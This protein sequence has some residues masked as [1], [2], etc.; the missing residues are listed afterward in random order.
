M[1]CFPAP[2]SARSK[3]L[4]S[5]GRGVCFWQR[6]SKSGFIH[7]NVCRKTFL[8]QW[9][10]WF[11]GW[12]LPTLRPHQNFTQ[13]EIRTFEN[14]TLIK[15]AKLVLFA[16][17][18]RWAVQD[19]GSALLCWP[20]DNILTY[21]SERFPR[22][23]VNKTAGVGSQGVSYLELLTNFHK[24]WTLFLSL[25]EAASLTCGFI[26]LLPVRARQWSTL[27]TSELSEV[28]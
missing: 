20:R 23:K 12:S 25:R 7:A 6:R 1:N 24:I 13:I 21:R 11:C 28:P 15:T 10:L 3:S 14:N 16:M 5:V 17:N 27:W 2:I 18:M 26:S 22:R 19:A 8:P 9:H 4:T